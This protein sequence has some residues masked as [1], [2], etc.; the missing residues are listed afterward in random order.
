[1]GWRASVWAYTL[2]R[3]LVWTSDLVTNALPVRDVVS[4]SSLDTRGPILTSPS[5]CVHLTTHKDRV[6]F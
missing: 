5:P 1:M 6:A 4:R 2:G 3:I